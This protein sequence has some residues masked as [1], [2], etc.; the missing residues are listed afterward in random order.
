MV[1]IRRSAILHAP[2]DQGAVFVPQGARILLASGEKSLADGR[3]PAGR[4]RLR[5]IAL[6][7]PAFRNQTAHVETVAGAGHGDIEQPVVFPKLLLLPFI[8]ALRRRA[9]AEIAA[10]GPQRHLRPFRII[11]AHGHADDAPFRIAG[12]GAGIRKKDDRRFQPLGAM[13]RH[14]PHFVRAGLHLAFQFRLGGFQ[15]VQE[16]GEA[17][18]MIHFMT[19]GH[20][21]ED[22]ERF[23]GLRP[24]ARKKGPPAAVAP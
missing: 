12:N 1:E 9:G 18:R 17:G 4:I 2:A 5:G 21:E 11:R 3:I 14:H 24:H 13:H 10:H 8:D 7:V 23:Q 19:A 16:A 20:V 22:I 15:K 6:L